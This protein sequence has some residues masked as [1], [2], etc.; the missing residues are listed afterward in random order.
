MLIY[1]MILIILMLFIETGPRAT[2]VVLAGEPVPAGTV[3]VTP[4]VRSAVPNVFGSAL[5][6]A[7]F[8]LLVV[9]SHFNSWE[10][11]SSFFRNLS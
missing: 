1:V 7:T 5:S 9:F 10:H 8:V 11:F 3:M 6:L 4:G 2:N